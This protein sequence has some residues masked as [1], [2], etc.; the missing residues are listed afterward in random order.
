MKQ[1][2]TLWVCGILLLTL[3][4]PV[5]AAAAG[6]GSAEAPDS[7]SPGITMVSAG[8]GHT[9]ALKRD[10]TVWA[11]GNNAYGQLGYGSATEGGTTPVQVQGLDSVTAIAAGGSH[12][13]ALKSDGTV[14]AWGENFYGELGDG[15]PEG[16]SRSSSPVQV[17]NLSSV[18]AIAAGNEYSLAVKSDGTVWSWGLNTWGQ[19]GDGSTT[20]RNVP[21]QI[22]GLGSV[23]DVAAGDSHVLALKNDGTVWAWGINGDGELGDGT[24]TNH[25][26]PVQVPHLDS[27][28]AIA[29]G[30]SHSLALK[31]DGTV[32]AWGR[33][34]SGELGNGTKTSS[35]SP[36]Q[37]T[38]LGSVT[39]IAAGYT[40]GFAL[41]SDGTVWA[42]GVN[43]FGQLGN[44]STTDSS[45]PVQVS[46]LDSV[47][48]ID[49]FYSNCMA[50]KSDGTLWGWGY[51]GSGVLGDGTM[52]DRDTPVQVQGPWKALPDAPQWPKGDVLTVT[53]VTYNSVQLNWQP[54][55]DHQTSVEKYLVYNVYYE[56]LATLNGD[57]NSYEVTGLSPDSHYSY[58]LIAVDTDGNQSERKTIEFTTAPY[59][60]TGSFQLTDTKTDTDGWHHYEYSLYNG[61]ISTPGQELIGSWTPP[62][63]YHA[64]VN[65]SMISPDGENYDLRVETVDNGSYSSL[66]TNVKPDGTESGSA[67]VPAGSTAVWKVKGH[68]LQDYSPDKKVIVYVRIEY[69]NH[70][71]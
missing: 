35:Y 5:Q 65:V 39:A 45:S 64:N 8:G 19:L 57:A 17:H 69:D 47:S 42:W 14:W 61:T 68:T 22:Q 53:N 4:V 34:Y 2:F 16:S 32:W 40:T 46:N 3:L 70:P 28:T 9:L 44:G 7:P 25:S 59:T 31:S 51:N 13:L 63:G 43:N 20:D 12:S 21:V 38:N 66:P 48:A 37:V 27:V 30:S 58:S 62:E 26:S 52:I 23:I 50:V 71:I 6:S 54:A 29:S 41:K 24:K 33:N 11:W 18:V 49:S 67:W 1:R 56:L 15:T 36:V 10:G 55:E 60:A